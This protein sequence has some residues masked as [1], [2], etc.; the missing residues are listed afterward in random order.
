[1]SWLGSLVRWTALAV[2]LGG[3]SPRGT[4]A[5]VAPDQGRLLV[6]SRHSGEVL[7]G[8]D[9]AIHTVEADRARALADAVRIEIAAGR[10]PPRTA[11]DLIVRV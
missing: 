7:G 11:D 2:M 6:L 4:D 1:M 8:E 10:A 5:G 3:S 9:F